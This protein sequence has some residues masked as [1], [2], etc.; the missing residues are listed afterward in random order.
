M[1]IAQVQTG[2]TTALRVYTL[3]PILDHMSRLHRSLGFLAPLLAGGQL[4][5]AQT[6]T[7]SVG[8]QVNAI[9]QLSI[10]GSPS[11]SLTMAPDGPSAAS[12]TSTASAS[13]SV[14]TN[15]SGAKVV[16]N[17]AAPMPAG[18]TLSVNLSAP[19]GARSAGMRSLTTSDVDLVTGV[20]RLKAAGLGLTYQLDATS[21]AG[22][23]PPDSRLVTFT[24]TGGV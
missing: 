22:R 7:Q 1:E 2:P 23:V 8:F 9:N 16:A 10:S 12:A 3:S 24:I 21:A 13:W 15:Q 14:T 11:L 17:I 18:V 6:A 20:S 4:A 5:G 19:P